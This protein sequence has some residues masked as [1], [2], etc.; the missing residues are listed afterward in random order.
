MEARHADP[1]YYRRQRHLF[2]VEDVFKAAVV[3]VV[4]PHDLLVLQFGLI[5]HLLLKL[6]FPLFDNSFPLLLSVG[7]ATASAVAAWVMEQS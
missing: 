4:A 2:G 6:L 5:A 3:L 7:C 1:Y